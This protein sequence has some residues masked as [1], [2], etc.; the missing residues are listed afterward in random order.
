MMNNIVFFF[1]ILLFSTNIVA[2]QSFGTV[3]KKFTTRQALPQSTN[4][5]FFKI[6]GCGISLAT[7]GT[8]YATLGKGH[9]QDFD[10]THKVVSCPDAI[11]ISANT[12]HMLP[13]EV[14]RCL[15]QTSKQ[16][17]F[18]YSVYNSS[19]SAGQSQVHF[20][21]WRLLVSKKKEIVVIPDSSTSSVSI[22]TYPLA[23]A[24]SH[25]RTYFPYNVIIQLQLRGGEPGDRIC[26][27]SAAPPW[28]QLKQFSPLERLWWHGT[29]SDVHKNA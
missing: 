21:L 10:H 16:R 5:R 6:G 27:E 26:I 2:M 25:Q 4:N 24:D 20:P 1:S 18:T 3:L 11:V 14:Y 29:S 22:E 19:D 8:L 15:G 9:L 17:P 28:V 12:N 23:M 7:F 13:G